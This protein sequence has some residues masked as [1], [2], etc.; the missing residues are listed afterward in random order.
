MLP[1]RYR[2]GLEAVVSE[3]I[4]GKRS[5]RAALHYVLSRYLNECAVMIQKTYRGHYGR[6]QYR[7]YLKVR[8]LQL[9]VIE[10]LCL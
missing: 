1:L 8:L 7:E 6:R 9:A 3:H 4:L 5:T 2:A 10:Y